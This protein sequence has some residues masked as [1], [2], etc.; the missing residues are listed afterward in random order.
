MRAPADCRARS[1]LLGASLAFALVL[2]LPSAAAASAH[3]ARPAS[4]LRLGSQTLKRCQVSP[5]AY[6]GRLAVPLDYGDPGSPRI[7]IAYRWYPASAP[8]GGRAWGTVVP[9]EGGP[10]YPSIGSVSYPSGSSTGGYSTMYG[11]LLQRWN[12]LAVDNR[13]TG[14]ST[15]LTCPALQSFSGPTD[16]EAFQQAAG[17]CAA[18]LNHRWQYAN[19]SWV[20]ASD[21]FTSA[22]AAEDLARV[23][24]ALGVGK[25]DLYGDSYGSFFAQVFAAR[26][27]RLLRSLTLDSTYETVGLDPWYRSTIA[28]MPADFDAACSRSPACAQAAPGPSWSRI[29]ALSERLRASPVSGV[30]PGPTGALVSVSMSSIGLVDLVNDAAGDPR[31]YR[32][33]DASARALLGA[34]DPAPL[35]R[36]Y[37]QRLYEDEDYFTVPAGEYSVELYLAVSCLDYPQLFDMSAGTAARAVQ[38]ASAQAALP[39]STFSPFSTGEWLQQDQNTEAYTA[40]LDWP[41]PTVAQPPIVTAPPLLPA[42]LPVLVLGGELDT[43]TP[44]GGVPKVLAELGGH[45]RFI[46]LA[47]STHVVGEGDTA[48]GSSLIERFVADPAALD[49]IDASCAPA[50][51]PIHTVG[52]YAAALAE[53]LPLQPAAGIDAS[54]LDLRLAAAAVSTAGDAI[55][56]YQAIEA[57]LDHGLAGGTVRGSEGGLLLRLHRDSLVPQVPISGTVTLTPDQDEADGYVARATLS[58]KAP[59]VRRASFTATWSTAG[60]GARAQVAGTVGTQRIAGTMPAP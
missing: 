59:G 10:G 21:L 47:N 14:G 12:M 38:L 37:A 23:I 49:S 28:A 41:S 29:V 7:S 60:A 22:P 1:A 40:C 45:S 33:L 56:R 25:V 43:W 2:A 26:F 30:V 24:G 58:A 53:E 31:I 3:S 51:P 50:V 6:C 34:G 32:E 36:L 18:A 20:H 52:V 54:S 55:S 8:P 35:L 4:R 5:L 44:P 15:P 16:S 39:A 13:G 48:C 11:S 57:R 46:E 19:G 17:G 27:P 9:V 42:S